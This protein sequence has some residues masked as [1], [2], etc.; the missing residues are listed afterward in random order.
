MA[1]FSTDINRIDK[2]TINIPRTV[3]NFPALFSSIRISLKIIGH[4]KRS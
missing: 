1:R 4:I 3:T 2:V